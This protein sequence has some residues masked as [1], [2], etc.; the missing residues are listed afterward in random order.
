MATK[1]FFDFV[2]ENKS[3]GLAWCCVLLPFV[4]IIWVFGAFAVQIILAHI[5]GSSWKKA[6]HQNTQ[7]LIMGVSCYAIISVIYFLDGGVLMLIGWSTVIML[8]I[9]KKIFRIAE[10]NEEKQITKGVLAIGLIIMFSFSISTI[11][12]ILTA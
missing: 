9:Y 6:I 3:V 7:G 4:H 5:G 1:E 2:A 11:L 8:I 10:T 12:V